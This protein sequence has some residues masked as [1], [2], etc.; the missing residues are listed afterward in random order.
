MAIIVKNGKLYVR[1]KLDGREYSAAAG[2]A[3]TKRN[4]EKAALL[5]AKMRTEILEGRGE[6]FK[7]R[8]TPFSKAVTMFLEHAQ[9]EY[10]PSSYRHLKSALASS[11]EFFGQEAIA[12]IAPGKIDAYKA[13]RRGVGIKE[14][15]IRHNLHAMSLVFQ[16]GIRANICRHNPVKSVTIPSDSEAV[17]INPLSA[18]DEAAYMA[19]CVQLGRESGSD[20]GAALYQDL[21]D[22][23]KLMIEQG[24][25]PDE[26]YRLAKS[27]ID[28]LSGH[29]YIQRGKTASAKRRLYLTAASR[30]ILARRSTL[31]GL[32]VFP[33]PHNVGKHREGFQKIHDCAVSVSGV[34]CVIYD[35]RHTFATRACMAG[36]PLPVVAA[37]LG[38]SP[39]NL[40]SVM[41]YVHVQA[42]DIDREMAKV[43]AGKKRETKHQE[44]TQGV[45]GNA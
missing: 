25:R 23:A 6:S 11:V 41:H 12:R 8:S 42:G 35:F 38:H 10:K 5:E 2:S 26:L 30:A 32:W 7:I 13:H 39:R 45:Q 18:E 28:L 31:P 4:R 15:S 9:G 16:F 29:V 20:Y 1:F 44:H 19:A 36:I 21:A 24:F 22:F 27:D 37:A 33:S 43:E 3:D 17:R 40:R 14:V 34:E